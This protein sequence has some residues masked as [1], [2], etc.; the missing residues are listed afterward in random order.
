MVADGAASCLLGILLVGYLQWWIGGEVGPV[1]SLLG[2]FGAC[3]LR[4]TMWRRESPYMLSRW[5]L[6]MTWRVALLC[7]F[8]TFVAGLAVGQGLKSA[9]GMGAAGVLFTGLLWILAGDIVAWRT[10]GYARERPPAKRPGA[11]WD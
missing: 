10:G 3:V 1:T 9:A 6:G 8:T 5:V 7:G 2:G 11:R 4:F